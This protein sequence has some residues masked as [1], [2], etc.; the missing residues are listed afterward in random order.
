MRFVFDLPPRVA[1]AI[2]D[3]MDRGA[4]PSADA[5][6]AEAIGRFL[7][8][9][10]ATEGPKCTTPVAPTD[11]GVLGTPTFDNS[12]DAPWVWGMVNRVFPL[13]V[14][15][16]ACAGLTRE[17]AISLQVAYRASANIAA[18]LGKQLAADDERVGRRRNEAR[19][20]ALPTGPDIEKSK[21]RFA[22]QFVGRR[23]A[24]RSYVGG[25]F[26]LGLLG[27]DPES[28]L[29][30][31]TE[32]GWKFAQLPNPIMDESDLT[33]ANLSKAERRFYLQKVAHAIPA[34][35][36]AAC[37]LLRELA[38]RPMSP[39]ELARRVFPR[40]TPDA[41]LVVGNTARV[42]AI[43]RLIDVGAVLRTPSGR[44]ATLEITDAGREALSAIA[45]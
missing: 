11:T 38:K 14:V 36:N 10:D 15:V 5:L 44:S 40:T 8:F 41:S 33:S 18:D 39:D 9:Y 37:A 1:K 4:F 17:H 43:G 3:A 25:A 20:V 12:A 22:Q 30:A 2:A 32:M 31:L 26:D 29:V 45:A 35:R 27:I 19:A 7:E 6:A 13:K 24:E 42:G 28:R 21:V 23:G 16:R 34:E